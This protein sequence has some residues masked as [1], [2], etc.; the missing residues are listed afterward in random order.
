MAGNEKRTSPLVSVSSGAVTGAGLPRAPGHAHGQVGVLAQHAQLAYAGQAV[1]HLT[2]LPGKDA[3]GRDG[4][5]QPQPAGAVDEVLVAGQRHVGVLRERLA[6]IGGHA[7]AHLAR[8]R[9]AHARLH[10]RRARALYG[11]HPGWVDGG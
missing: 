2:Q 8:G 1:D 5:V 10:Q 3:P 7:P 9:S 4:F 11:R 6:R